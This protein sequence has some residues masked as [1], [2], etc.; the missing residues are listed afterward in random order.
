MVR[1]SELGFED[2]QDKKGQNPQKPLPKSMGGTIVCGVVSA[3]NNY[4]DKL[5]QIDRKVLA[6]DTES[7][8]IFS[9]TT[10]KNVEA[11]TIRGIS[12]YADKKKQSWKLL[13]KIPLGY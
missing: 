7:G 1:A 3:G 12:D 9:V 6:I 8:G 4:N 10:R 2:I 13:H 11:L 5:K